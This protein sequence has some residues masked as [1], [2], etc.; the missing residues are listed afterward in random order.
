MLSIKPSISTSGKITKVAGFCTKSYA[1]KGKNITSTIEQLKPYKAFVHTLS[2]D[3]GKEFAFHQMVSFE[4]SADFNFARPYHSPE[5]GL[6]QHT[7]GLAQQYFP[8]SQS[9]HVSLEDV[10]SLQTPLNNRPKKALNFETS[11]E[12]FDR[13]S[14]D[15]LYLRAQ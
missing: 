15:M 14:L 13:I 4:L 3:N 12:V 10:L 11:Q 6:N 7:N 8:K 9:F 2:G 1:I 5:R